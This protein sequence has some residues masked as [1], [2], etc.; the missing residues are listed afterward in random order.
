MILK[1]V[2]NAGFKLEAAHA[3]CLGAGEG[4]PGLHP[5]PEGLREVMLR[6]TVRDGRR[7]A[8]ERFTAEF[9]PLITSGPPGLAGYA[10]G[11]SPVRPVFAYWPALVPRELVTPRVEVRSAAAW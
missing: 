11:R 6:V 4:V 2:A 10:I 5:A 7:E 9:A 1:R 3:E 8:V